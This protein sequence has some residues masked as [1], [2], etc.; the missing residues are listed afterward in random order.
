MHLDINEWLR[1]ERDWAE[2]FELRDFLPDGSAFRAALLEDW[3][4]AEAMWQTYGGERP[5]KP[6]PSFRG[7]TTE[8]LNLMDI[9]DL[10]T[11]VLSAVANQK[12]PRH[13]RPKS[14]YEKKKESVTSNALN[15][16]LSALLPGQVPPSE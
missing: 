16:A 14:A 5:P 3:E 13:P 15:G 11:T 10:V 1:G 2:F 7:L 6:E 9:K 12:V 8:V 4:V